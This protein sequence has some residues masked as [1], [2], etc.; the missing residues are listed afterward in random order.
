MALSS[1][2][3]VPVV[4]PTA[5]ELQDFSSLIEKHIEEF[6]AV[7]HRPHRFNSVSAQAGLIKII[8]PPGWATNLPTEKDALSFT[9]NKPIRQELK[10]SQVCA[11][12]R[13]QRLNLCLGR[14]GDRQ[15]RAKERPRARF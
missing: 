13:S 2:F 12:V 3:E 8:P 15:C 11:A 5:E 4:R 6:R 7:R 10:G 1:Y 9:V 14:L